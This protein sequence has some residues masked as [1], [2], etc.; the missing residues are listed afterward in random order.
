MEHG[1]TQFK[2]YLLGNLSEDEI[3]ETEMQILADQEFAENM[4]IV[5]TD[6]IEEYLDGELSANDQ[7]SFEENY[8][9]CEP[10]LKKVE[11]LKSVKK[12]AES[13]SPAKEPMPSFFETLKTK[14]NLRPLTLA[15][16]TIALI[17]AVGF[18]SYFV[19]KNS[20]GKPEVLISLNKVY[21]NERPLDSRISD[22]D[23]A[24]K[25]EG[26][27]GAN[28]KTNDDLDLVE[29]SA[30]TAVKQN[31]TVENLHAL[32]QVYLTK[33]DFDKAIEQFEKAI[34]QNP[35]TAKLHNDLGVALLEKGKLAK[36]KCVEKTKLK[37]DCEDEKEPYLLSLAKANEEFAKAIELDKNSLE[38]NFNQA[39]CIQELNLPNQ[40]KEAWENYLK[41]DST[42]KWADEARKNLETVE[43][44]KPVSKTK[45]EILRDFLAAKDADDDEKAWEVL[46]RNRE[47]I[48]GKLIPQQLTFLFVDSKVKGDETTAKIALDALVYASKLEEKKSGDLF[49]RDLANYY[50]NVSDNKVQELKIA[51]DSFRKG[52]DICLKGKYEN[53]FYEFESSR[54]MFLRSKNIFE[55]KLLDT[56]TTYCKIRLGK[57]KESNDELFMLATF[58]KR[59]NYKW[60]SSQSLLWLGINA[61]SIKHFSKAIEYFKEVSLLAAETSDLLGQEQILETISGAYFLLGQY[62]KSLN[63]TQRNL[64]LGTSLDSS[65]RQKWRDYYSAGKLFYEMK[66]FNAAIFY[67]QEALFVAKEYLNEKTFDYTNYVDLG[68]MYGK[69]GNFDKAFELIEAA[70]KLSETFTDEKYKNLCFAY[71][72]LKL[73]HLRRQTK[74]YRQASENYQIAVNYYDNNEFQSNGYEA[75]KGLLLNY[76]EENNDEAFQKELPNVISIF[77]EYRVKIKEEQNRNTFF[78]NEQDV[79]DIAAEYEFEKGNFANAFDYSEDSRSRSLLDL[80]NSDNG[81]LTGKKQRKNLSEPFKLAQIQAG[82]PE[83][84]QLLEYTVLQDKVL[85]YSITK[86]S[87]NAVK[88]DIFADNLKEKVSTY[89]EL[90]SKNTEANEYLDLSKELYQLLITPIKDKLDTNKEIFIIPDKSLNQV[91]F[92]ALFSDKYLIEEFKISY[93]ASANVFLLCSIK[94]KDFDGK[95]NEILLGVGNPSFNQSDYQYKL[96]RL[97]FA[98]VEVEEI[99]KL[100]QSK[101]LTENDATKNKIKEGLK[102]ADILQFSGHYLV[103]ERSP[104]LSSFVLAGSKESNL[105]NYEIISEKLPHIRLIVLSA[106][107]TGVETYYKGE[108]MIGASRTFLA[109]GVP[110]VIASQWKVDSEA[111]KELMVR[112]HQI[113]KQ[114]KFPTAE[115]LRQSQIEMLRSEKYKQPYYWAAFASIGGYA[116]F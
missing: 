36:S 74:N 29:L 54:K 82:M 23:Y 94:A 26:T 107:N 61:K 67:E 52:N 75:H 111:T 1:Q 64:I 49:W 47:M 77:N 80:M 48:T 60:L 53:A 59:N 2:N 81:S 55:P 113:R 44:N 42:S 21:K 105:A 84:T 27:R 70:Q 87:L 40:A 22:F 97:P 30:R 38:A 89:R 108:G 4:E 71:T 79:Y 11:F 102:T 78:E 51:Q 88:S 16:G 95:T 5:E 63:F 34:K 14:F 3:A 45:D 100:Y 39:L 110:L 31:P 6:L 103:D 68:L 19:W 91:S 112:L 72:N 115:A 33:K 85:I 28:D 98:K 116:Q 57:L 76:L 50:Q 56:M 8:L 15:F 106:C 73:G 86:N 99:A 109:T 93:A 9:N 101:P 46:S 62:N 83:N 90:I 24:P 18:T 10:R 12:F 69:I 17:C 114:E 13:Q 96:E 43:S 41:L 66:F 104:V 32:G 20:A 35:N 65:L 25:V 7:K 58:C 92:A 37:Q